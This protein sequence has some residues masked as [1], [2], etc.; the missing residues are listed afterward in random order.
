MS[1][2]FTFLSTAFPPTAQVTAFKGREA[3]SRTYEFDIALKLTGLDVDVAAAVGAR[4]TLNIDRGLGAPPFVFHGILASVELV[5]DYGAYGLYLARLV[6]TYWQ[7]TLT[8]HSRIFTDASIPEIIEAILKEG[9]LGSNDYRISL[10]NEYPKLEHVCQYRESNYDF[11]ARL[12]EREGMYFYFEQ[13]EDREILVFTDTRSAHKKLAP[14]PVKYFPAPPGDVSAGESI[15]SFRCRSNALPGRVKVTD[16]NYLKPS[17][18]VKGSAELSGKG[19]IVLYGENVK[20]PGEGKRYASIRAEEIAARQTVY[21]GV[22]PQFYLRPGYV[23][24]LEEHPRLAFNS[25]YLTIE[26]EHLG[27]QSA[28][29]EDLEMLFGEEAPTKETYLATVHAIPHTTQFRA[30]RKTPWPRIDGV[31]DGVVDGVAASPYAQIDAHGRYKVNIFFD[32][33]DAIDGSRSTWVR[34]LQPHGGTVEGHHFPLRK[35][36][37]VHLVFLGGDPDRP[38]IV[39]A[40]HNAETPSVVTQGNYTKNLIRSGSNNFI[41]MEDLLGSTHVHI[42]A[43]KLNSSLHLGNGP[44]NFDLRTDGSGHIY[45]GVNFDVDVMANKTEDV[46]GTITETYVGPFTTTVTNPVT[47]TYNATLDETVEGAVT[48]RYNNILDLQVTSA[49]TQV[50]KDI[51]NLQVVG[52]NTEKFDATYDETVTGKMT[53]TYLASREENVTGEDKL[54]VTGTQNINVTSNATEKIGGVYD[55]TVVGDMKTSI[56]G[57]Q[58]IQTQGPVQWFKA[59]EFQGF[60]AGAKFDGHAGFALDWF[61]GAKIS[62]FGGLKVDLTGGVSLAL[63]LGPM[64]TITPVAMDM[65]ATNL[66]ALGLKLQAIGNKLEAK[67]LSLGVAGLHVN[68]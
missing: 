23:F 42:Y 59:A 66:N 52:A 14:K 53:G 18:E 26:I 63:T 40:A 56:N 27:N 24:V 51:V 10:W 1:E 58:K 62:L 37:E 64:L 4:G 29:G 28:S 65:K 31:V 68:T 36:T 67:G 25:D 3:I 17:L 9:G 41:E 45:T 32:E 34:M 7:L 55:L 19:D 57:N 21:T 16:Y 46:H 50:Y 30:E 2:I 22:G 35:G 5:N 6:P 33:G 39:G 54:T 60:T 44:Y 11:I 43:P 15:R 8:R 12:A 47:Q 38:V 13:S 49:T 48:V 20:T 61:A